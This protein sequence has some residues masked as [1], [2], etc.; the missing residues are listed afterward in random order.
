M[1]ICFLA[2]ANN[3]HTKKWCEFFTDNGHEVHV[4]S[5][6]EGKIE[7]TTVHYIDSGVK[8]TA[9]DIKKIKYLSKIKEVKKIIKR[10][11]PD[12]VNAHYATS[13]GMVASLLKI[14]FFLSV[15]GTDVYIFPRKSIIHKLYFKY[16]LKKATYIFSTS[17]TMK[18]EIKKYTKK[19]VY[20]TPFGVKMDLFKPISKKENNEFV[21][22]T[23]KSLKE[24]YGISYI[25]KAIS[26]IK[27]ERPDINIKT[28]IAG[29]GEKEDEY[30]K[31]AKDLDVSVYWLGYI[32]QEQAAREWAN[33]DVALIPSTD[34]S[35]SFG[36][37]AIEA[38]ACGVPVI[39]SNI[40]GLLETTTEESRIVISK[41]NEKELACA[42]IELYDNKNNRI[43]MGKKGREYVLNNF[44][45]NKCFKYIEE[46]FKK[47]K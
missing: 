32:S 26:L 31:L 14:R 12:I 7:N 18:E 44:E 15:W 11:N 27:K 24:K 20:V 1:K 47:L 34:D 38:E 23:I 16:I 42:I 36:V 2:P 28:I 22:G 17:I 46:L 21:V 39:I 29:T 33:M 43:T 30:K 41:K 10:I 19:H 25:I 3:Y 5:F 37:S 40:P 8:T 35:E 45:Y 13:Y 9:K 4:I 6:T